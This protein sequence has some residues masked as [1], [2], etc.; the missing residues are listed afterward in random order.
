VYWDS[1]NTTLLFGDIAGKQKNEILKTKQSPRAFVS[2]D[3]SMVFLY[4]PL[5]AQGGPAE[6]FAIVKT[7][8]TDYRELA[9]SDNGK[10][11]QVL[12]LGP[13]CASWSPDNRYLVL[14]KPETAGTRM[15]KLSVADSKIQDLLPGKPVV[16]QPVRA[17][18]FSPDGRYI[19]YSAG[20]IYIIPAQ[21][22][23]SRLIADGAVLVDWSTDGR[24][25]LIA[26]PKSDS[27]DLAAV[28]VTAGQP[29][30]E[31]ITLPSLP[32]PILF[33]YTIS[34]GALIVVPQVVGLR[35]VSLGV[36]DA[37]EKSITWSPLDL[38]GLRIPVPV[39]WSPDNGRFAYV[40]GATGST[41]RVVRIKDLTRNEDRE[42]FRSDQAILGCAW[43]HH[44]P[45]IFCAQSLE[46]K[47]NILS[48]SA[49]SGEVTVVG[50]LAGRKLMEHITSDDR[51]LVLARIETVDWVEW[52]I[53]TGQETRVPF[54]R[55]EDERWSLGRITN[56]GQ[57]GVMTIR[58]ATGTDSDWRPL[59]AR[60]VPPLGIPGPVPIRL[61]TDGNW[62]VYH[63]RD[64][65]GKDGLYRV[66]TARAGEPERLGDY[67]TASLTS[68]M[69]P[70]RDARKFVV[71]APV[72]RQWELWS[73]ENF[74][75]PPASA[76]ANPTSKAGAR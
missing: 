61:S 15:L 14:C 26:K 28:P 7:D 37:N 48:V 39:A 59:V 22:G 63:D 29:S 36:L 31:P 33:A 1:T 42:L 34:N 27:T 53:E 67:P 46:N 3:L 16:G 64:T 18:W 47:T 5:S 30:G 58:P 13:S 40:S 17:A 19:A 24:Y 57:P 68:L 52:D 49:E 50:S 54:I 6:K 51:K 55:S 62:V 35:A 45:T 66:A 76:T 71:N 8:G 38:I 65:D 70:S 12:G 9:L 20:P 21:G 25:I 56:S 69:N 60:R 72:L 74:L 32:G 23:N 2:R 10:P 43:A 41:A 44:Q 73:L 75:P 11:L 4:F